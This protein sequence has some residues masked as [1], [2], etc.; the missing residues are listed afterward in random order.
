MLASDMKEATNLG[1]PDAEFFIFLDS[2]W[3]SMLEATSGL[4]ERM[5]AEAVDMMSHIDLSPLSSREMLS[6]ELLADHVTTLANVLQVGRHTTASETRLT[7]VLH[8]NTLDTSP[9]L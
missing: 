4:A 6:K 8:Y 3:Y 7:L 1:A 9:S 5:A 2:H